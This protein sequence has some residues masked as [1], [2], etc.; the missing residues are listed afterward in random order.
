MDVDKR[1]A[2]IEKTFNGLDKKNLQVLNDF[3]DENIDFTD[4]VGNIKGEL[5]CSFAE[6]DLTAPPE[7]VESFSRMVHDA[8]VALS[9]MHHPGTKHGYALPSRDVYDEIATG[10]DWQM[11]FA[12]F[13]RQ[14]P[15]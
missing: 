14:M 7:M 15:A 4:P 8:G 1:K 12:M 6:D 10:R 11:I 13:A 2:L 3:Y 5:Y 9:T